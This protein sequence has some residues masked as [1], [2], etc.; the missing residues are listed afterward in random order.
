MKVS[1][2][3]NSGAFEDVELLTASLFLSINQGQSLALGLPP[4]NQQDQL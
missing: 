2:G 3:Q 1:S 4:C